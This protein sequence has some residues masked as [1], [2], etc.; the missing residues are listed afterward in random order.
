[1]SPKPHMH[2]IQR[3]PQIVRGF[4]I[5]SITEL[6]YE[7]LKPRARILIYSNAEFKGTD[8]TIVSR[9]REQI[10]K[11]LVYKSVEVSF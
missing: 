3:I 8:L 9:I 6:A 7:Q 2:K 11:H 5:L 10:S 4:R 1:M